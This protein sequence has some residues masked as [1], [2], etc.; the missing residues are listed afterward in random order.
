MTLQNIMILIYFIPCC[1]C[2][3][4]DK[5]YFVPKLYLKEKQREFRI[6]STFGGRIQIRIKIKVGS[7]SA[8]QWPSP[9]DGL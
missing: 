6:R 2:T 7:G 1:T 5:T 4:G 9:L 8:S 3:Y